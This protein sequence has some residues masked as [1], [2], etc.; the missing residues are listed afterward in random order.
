MLHESYGVGGW[1]MQGLLL[2]AGVAAPLLSANALMTERPLPTFLEILGPP[3]VRSWPLTTRLLGFALIVT[4]VIAVATALSLVFDAR[5]RDFPF[6]ALT[7]AVVPFCTVAFLNPAKSG[8]RPIAEMVFA[9]LFA[10]TVP[11]SPSTRGCITGNRCGPVPPIS[12]SALRCG[13]R[14]PLR[15]PKRH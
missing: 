14:A 12:C 13:G 2:A 7:M 9:G 5:W 11:T 10:L 8:A 4:T 15:S 1:L 6:A 3:E